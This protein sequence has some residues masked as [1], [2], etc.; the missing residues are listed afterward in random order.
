[1]QSGSLQ[2]RVV[3]CIYVAVSCGAGV[4][5]SWCFNYGADNLFVF[6]GMSLPFAL[7][8]YAYA[9]LFGQISPLEAPPSWKRMLVLWAG[10]PLSLAIGALTILAETGVM[11]VVGFRV[12][13]LPLYSLRLLVGEAAACLAWAA[14]LLIWSRKTG[15]GLS[16]KHLLES[17]S[18][19]FGGVLVA[20]GLS[21]PI[22]RSFHKDIYFLLTSVLTTTISALI[23]IFPRAKEQEGGTKSIAA[24]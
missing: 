7:A 20:Y 23:L 11:V 19:L 15:F 2:P 14:C 17:S 4:W 10:M 24:A 22:L 21:T 1:M 16:R 13:N 5:Q 6:I 9:L 18:A 3:D 8:S 12:D